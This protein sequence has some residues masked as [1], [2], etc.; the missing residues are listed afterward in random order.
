MATDGQTRKSPVK[1]YTLTPAAE[2]PLLDLA[3]RLNVK[4]AAL[5]DLAVRQ[6]LPRFSGAGISTAEEDRDAWTP[7]G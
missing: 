4:P 1:G 2:G 3:A 6:M 7:G 5:V